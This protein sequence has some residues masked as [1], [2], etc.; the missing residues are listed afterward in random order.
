MWVTGE[1]GTHTV[2]HAREWR[3]QGKLPGEQKTL[4]PNPPGAPDGLS[5]DPILIP[6]HNSVS[7]SYKEFQNV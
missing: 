5:P 4:A 1:P 3:S 2:K 7:H 6:C